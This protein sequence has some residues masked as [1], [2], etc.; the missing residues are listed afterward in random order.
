MTNALTT[1]KPSLQALKTPAKTIS[2]VI[3]TMPHGQNLAQNLKLIG[4]NTLRQLEP[5]DMRVHILT[6]GNFVLCCFRALVSAGSARMAK[7]TP[8]EDYRNRQ[9]VQTLIREFGGFV[10][11]FVFPLKS[12]MWGVRESLKKSLSL[13]FAEQ[14]N[15]SVFTAFKDTAKQ[16]GSSVLRKPLPKVDPVGFR[17]SS[18]AKIIAYNE[19][20]T[21]LKLF[22]PLLKHLS[23]KNELAKLGQLYTLLPP[24]IAAIPTLAISGFW[25]EKFSL[26]SSGKMIDAIEDVIHDRRLRHQTPKPLPN[27]PALNNPGPLLQSV[28]PPVN[29]AAAQFSA[30][31]TPVLSG[32]ATAKPALVASTAS[33][34]NPFASPAASP[35]TLPATVTP[36]RDSLNPQTAQPLPYNA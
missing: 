16:F 18:G 12:I 6:L 33:A 35:V 27:L 30:L 28:L 9:T 32:A 19:K 11:T 2:R 7:G 3:H 29:A 8:Q 34:V 31:T 4:N 17:F 22:K 21:A 14:S 26:N 25:L 23:G 15:Y 13:K 24:V 10:L 1:V 5:G 36:L 20:S